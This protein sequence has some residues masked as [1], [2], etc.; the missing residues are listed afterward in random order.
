MKPNPSGR[1][2]ISLALAPVY[3]ASASPPRPKKPHLPQ[4]HLV[5]SAFTIASVLQVLI[6]AQLPNPLRPLNFVPLLT[7]FG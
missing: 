5:A 1:L 4:C 6:G 7:D 2:H 3:S